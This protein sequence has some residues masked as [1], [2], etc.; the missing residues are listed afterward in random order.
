MIDL[1]LPMDPLRFDELVNLG[2]SAIPTLA[3]RWT[4]HNVHD[5]G[6]MLMELVAWI[7]E[8]Q[9][10]SLAR[11]RRD[12]RRA[13]AHML[14][15][16][17]EGPRPAQGLLWPST[18]RP[19]EAPPGLIIPS[20]SRATARTDIPPFF[21]SNSVQLTPASLIRLETRY[22]DGVTHDWT[23]VNAQ[24]SATFEPFGD[25]SDLSVRLLLTFELSSS[26]SPSEAAALSLG[27]EVVNAALSLN[28]VRGGQKLMI[29][30]SDANG[31]RQLE[32]K[33]MTCGL[34]ESGVVL[35][36]TGRIFPELGRFQLILKSS[37]GGFERP[38]RIR[39]IG[40]NVLPVTQLETVL[41]EGLPSFGQAVPNEQYKLLRDGLVFSGNRSGSV[42]VTIAEK[43]SP[44]SWTRTADLQ[45]STPNDRHFELDTGQRLL[46]FGNGINGRLV[47]EGASIAVEYQVSAGSQGN[48]QPG[49]SWNVQ[50]VTG[51][52]ENHE[53]TAG[54]RDATTLDDLR[55]NA[56]VQVGSL[57]PLVTAGDVELAV[58]SFTDLGVTRAVEL[59]YNAKQPPGDRVLVVTGPQDDPSLPVLQ[60]SAEFLKAVR[61]RIVPKLPVGGRIQVTGPSYVQIRI[62]AILVSARNT[63]PNVV[64][65]NAVTA[66]QQRFATVTSN[67]L[68]Q[69]PLGRPVSAK[70][71]QGWLRKV[72]GVAQVQEVDLRRAGDSQSQGFI[73]LTPK[74]LPSLQL[75]EADI[76]VVRPAVG[77]A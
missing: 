66:L 51:N 15:I 52:F 1:T 35:L 16:E 59:P 22:S 53:M 49:V 65:Q 17:A 14:G 30:L 72:E 55:D 24:S 56:R 29:S 50:G 41:G 12:E 36:S 77:S 3:P 58:K 40:I 76:A 32:I 20:A 18:K 67:G 68:N 44:F 25:V 5:P 57:R 9:M 47:P 19:P 34:L 43:G 27:F 23:R 74:E 69:W 64:R 71:V 39:R 48:I 54:G 70:S 60:Q 73:R 26:A 2:R 33:D 46:T 63:D 45:H 13:F 10:Y 31:E 4:D 7:A 11:M 62:T 8:A 21:V 6:I 28:A 38:P 75:S 42:K 37:T 61:Q